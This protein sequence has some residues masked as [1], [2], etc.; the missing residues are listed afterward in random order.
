MDYLSVFDAQIDTYFPPSSYYL[1]QAPYTALT[2]DLYLVGT[3][4]AQQY[5]SPDEGTSIM[6][7]YNALG[8]SLSDTHGRVEYDLAGGIMPPESE[9]LPARHISTPQAHLDPYTP[10]L[11]S[12]APLF[13]PCTS[14]PASF[15]SAASSASPLPAYSPRRA[16]A[17]SP[18]NKQVELSGEEIH[19]IMEGHP[20]ICPICPLK[21]RWIRKH[22][23][24]RHLASHAGLGRWICCGVPVGDAPL[25]G[26]DNTSQA[27]EL[28][29]VGG[30]MKDFSRRD[31]YKRHLMKKNIGCI[32]SMAIAKAFMLRRDAHL[33]QG[34][35]AG[36]ARE[37]EEFPLLR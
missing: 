20:M 10:S 34:K 23:V 18:R 33:M 8:L 7:P 2:S 37:S 19:Q 4:H 15:S 24:W 6:S 12:D 27:H 25:L 21:F 13:R 16:L 36:P 22:D 29:Y 35:R 5:V 9:L 26:I 14:S 11:Q 31:A 3:T 1:A 32:G 28:E 17:T 30:C